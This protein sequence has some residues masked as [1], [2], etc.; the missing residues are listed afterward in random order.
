MKSTMEIVNGKM[1]QNELNV[2][3][4]HLSSSYRHNKGKKASL[5]LGK[6]VSHRILFS[7]R[8]HDLFALS[9]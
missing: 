5:P 9:Y 8:H 6:S 7:F 2:V 3:R 4:Q 1:E